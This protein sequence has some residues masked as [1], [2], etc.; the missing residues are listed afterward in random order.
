MRID[1]WSS[2]AKK[3]DVWKIRIYGMKQWKVDVD[4]S[5]FG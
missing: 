3:K 2:K 1:D 4:Y 5:Q